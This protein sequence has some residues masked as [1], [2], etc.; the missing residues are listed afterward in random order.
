MNKII[1][2]ILVP[3]LIIAGCVGGGGQ[4]IHVRGPENAAVTIV[5]YSDFQ[6]PACGAAEPVIEQVLSTYPDKVRFIY[7]DMPLPFHSYAQKASEAA[8]CAGQQDKYWEMHDL[9]FANQEDLTV[10]DLKM[11]ASEL[12]LDTEKFN[13]CLDS[14]ATSGDVAADLE[15]GKKAG[16]DATPS[17]FVNGQKVVGAYPFSFWQSLI[18]SAK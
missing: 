9:L 6:C 16:V 12:G 14:G 4:V 17:F 18:E 2:A 10:S 8:E 1:F 15:E 7:K 3:V 13:S 11:Y 5:E